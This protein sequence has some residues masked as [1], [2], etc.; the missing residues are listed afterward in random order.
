[1]EC[2]DGITAFHPSGAVGTGEAV[3]GSGFQVPGDG[4]KAASRV[5]PGTRNLKPGTAR[6][7]AHNA[8][9]VVV[10]TPRGTTTR[11]GDPGAGNPPGDEWPD[12]LKRIRDAGKLCQ[13]GVSPEGALNVVRQLGGKGFQFLV[14]GNM[15]PEEADAFLKDLERADRR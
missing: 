2:G 4:E 6:S 12:V 3:S 8:A 15:T 9:A 1:M 7:P 10:V 14:G 11:T 13:I 5:P